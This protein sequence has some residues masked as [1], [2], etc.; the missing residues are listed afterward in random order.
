M[1]TWVPVPGWFILRFDI[2]GS[3][4]TKVVPNVVE[5]LI[6]SPWSKILE[7]LKYELIVPANTKISGSVNKTSTFIYTHNRYV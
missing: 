6:L 3:F 7:L 2:N 4:T 5:S 1:V